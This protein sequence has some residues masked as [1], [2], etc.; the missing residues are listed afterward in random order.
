MIAVAKARDVFEP[1]L[2]QVR[3]LIYRLSYEFIPVGSCS[4]FTCG[5]VTSSVVESFMR[6]ANCDMTTRF[7]QARDLIRNYMDIPVWNGICM[8][9]SPLPYLVSRLK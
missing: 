3:F 7:C 1:F 8:Q 6:W 4:P 5:I 9:T 2:H